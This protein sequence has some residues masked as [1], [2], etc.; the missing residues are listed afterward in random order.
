VVLLLHPASAPPCFLSV[1]LLDAGLPTTLGFCFDSVRSFLAMS[2]HLRRTTL[3][4]RCEPQR[5]QFIAEV[6]SFFFLPIP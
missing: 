6:I 4:P 5:T 3:P 2:A 1:L